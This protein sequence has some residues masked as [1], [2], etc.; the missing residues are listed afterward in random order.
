MLKNGAGDAAKGKG[1]VVTK[2]PGPCVS[3]KGASDRQLQPQRSPRWAIKRRL[4]TTQEMEHRVEYL[5]SDLRP[6]VFIFEENNLVWNPR[7]V[8]TGPL[9]GRPPAETGDPGHGPP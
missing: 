3:V 6:R 8:E 1:V 2:L 4:E 5:D 7:V 9:S